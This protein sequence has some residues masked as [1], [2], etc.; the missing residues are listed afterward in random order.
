MNR[1]LLAGLCALAVAL[2]GGQRSLALPST[3]TAG[4]LEPT[5]PPAPTTGSADD[6]YA[7][8]GTDRRCRLSRF[9]QRNAERRFYIERTR[10]LEDSADKRRLEELEKETGAVR[11]FRVW[12][13]DLVVS[14]ASAIG[15]GGALAG[16]GYSPFLRLEGGFASVSGSDYTSTTSSDGTGYSSSSFYGSG[17][18]LF[19]RGKWC[20][21][22]STVTPYAALGVVRQGWSVSTYSSPSSGPSSTATQVGVVHA[23]Q[24]S[25]GVDMLLSGGL[26]AAVEAQYVLPWYVQV[27]DEASGIPDVAQQK[28]LARLVDRNAF[29]VG[30]HFGWTFETP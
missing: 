28:Q 18:S 19:L 29:G 5:P 15:Y 14:T 11:K 21:M 22:L 26:H 23:A 8:C 2:L 25:L 20:F 24:G 16:Y 10:R 7:D 30:L 6:L 9:S 17:T 1:A 13:V 4:A 3:Q 27:R 12:E